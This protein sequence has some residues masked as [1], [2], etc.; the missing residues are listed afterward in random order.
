MNAYQVPPA[1]LESL[2][3]E[4]PAVLDAAVIG[5]P[6]SSTGEK[7][8]AFVVLHKGADVTEKNIMEHVTDRVAPYKRLKEVQFVDSIH[9]N[10]TGKILR[11]L[12]LEDHM[13]HR[14]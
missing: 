9:K 7:P 8:K 2:I 13:K 3:K 11:R 6:D 4:H 12:L 1:E 14:K 5:I 10:P